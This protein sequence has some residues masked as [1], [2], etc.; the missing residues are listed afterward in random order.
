MGRSTLGRSGA[1]SGFVVAL[2]VALLVLTGLLAYQAASSARSHRRAAEEAIAEF[3]RV[4][5]WEYAGA[6]RRDLY[7]SLTNPGLELA[8]F[9]GAKHDYQAF[10]SLEGPGSTRR[11]RPE[12]MSVRKSSPPASA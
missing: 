8:A 5:A 3:A 10:D 6:A 4:A 9:S 7:S 11:K 12:A 1:N 2:L